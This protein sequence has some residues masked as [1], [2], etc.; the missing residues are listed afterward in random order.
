M[1][2]RFIGAD[3]EGGTP[4]PAT[5]HGQQ[6]VAAP[7]TKATPTPSLCDTP[8]AMQQVCFCNQHV[9][10]FKMCLACRVAVT[11]SYQLLQICI[12]HVLYVNH[13]ADACKFD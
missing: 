1:Y 10:M 9:S 8:N 6:L 11:G 5:V 2:S 4:V 13:E 7:T 3:G 12:H